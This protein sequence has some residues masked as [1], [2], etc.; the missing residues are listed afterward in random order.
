MSLTTMV[1]MIQPA[2][3]TQTGS[4]ASGTSGTGSASDSGSGSEF[5]SLMQQQSQ[6]S[7]SQNSESSSGSASET[8]DETVVTETTGAATGDTEVTDAQRELMAALLFQNVNYRTVEVTPEGE[9]VLDAEG[10]L[11]PVV[12]L[13]SLENEGLELGEEVEVEIELSGELG[14][15]ASGAFEF[16][17]ADLEVEVEVEMPEIALE[18]PEEVQQTDSVELE[19]PVEI[20]EVPL[21]ET[22]VDAEVVVEEGTVAEE[23]ENVAVTRDTA[24]TEVKTEVVS[25][26]ESEV[27]IET[28]VEGNGGQN[29]TLFRDLQSTPVKVAETVNT[30]DPDMDMQMAKI[31][32]DAHEAGESTVTIR[33]NPEGL[34]QVTVEITQT[35]EGAL[36][37]VLQ[38]ADDA[39]TSLLRSHMGQIAQAMTNS[40]V[41]TQVTVEVAEPEESAGQGMEQENPEGRE[42]DKEE[43]QQETEPI[44][45]EDFLH[46]MRLGLNTFNLDV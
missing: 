30:E 8:T 23:T 38:A 26:D 12:E 33:L 14:D 22:E 17:I 7:T 1:E 11:E 28:S 45:S 5:E 29:A 44:Y 6:S 35:V 43:K 37:I 18:V 10:T 3:S 46:Q 27:K 15:E 42:E 41:S 9:V 40:G 31:I 32:Q 20:E 25:E 39:A 19:I 16:E 34:G 2:Q 13:D 4:S 24:E 21:E 36:Q